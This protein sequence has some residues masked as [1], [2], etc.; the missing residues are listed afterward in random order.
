MV[1]PDEERSTKLNRCDDSHYKSTEPIAERLFASNWENGL[2][3]L[4]WQ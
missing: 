1:R 3:C 4:F 2:Q